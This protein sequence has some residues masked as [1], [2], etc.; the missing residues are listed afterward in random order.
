MVAKACKEAGVDVTQT[1]YEG[2]SHDFQLIFSESEAGM[3]A[4]D[5][6]KEFIGRVFL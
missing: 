6:I 4:W 2:Q 5:Q 1:T 3:K